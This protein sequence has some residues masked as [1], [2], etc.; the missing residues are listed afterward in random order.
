MCKT[1]LMKVK[2]IS[3]WKVCDPTGNNEVLSKSLD[4]SECQGTEGEWWFC[5]PAKDPPCIVR[6]DKDEDFTV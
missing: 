6:L 3:E 1:K 2:P 5:R 4:V